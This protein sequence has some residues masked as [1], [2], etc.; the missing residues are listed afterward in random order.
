MSR[1]AG[2]K[3]SPETRA[4]ISE[5]NRGRRLSL[6]SRAKIAE[7]NR[8]AKLGHLVSFETRMKISKA[9][10]GPRHHAYSHGAYYA[11]RLDY[12]RPKACE[13]CGAEKAGRHH[14]DGNPYNQKHSNVQWLCQACHAKVHKGLNGKFQSLLGR[15]S[16]E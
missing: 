13:K 7:G 3:H 9:K 14:T 4:K 1:P 16:D 2:F 5:K 12:R 15:K 10:T 8:L 11:R 6:E